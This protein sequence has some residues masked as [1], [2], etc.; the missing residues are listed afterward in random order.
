MSEVELKEYLIRGFQYVL[1]FKFSTSVLK[2][3]ASF[4]YTGTFSKSTNSGVQIRG[5]S[6]CNAKHELTQSSPA[7]YL[8]HFSRAVCRGIRPSLKMPCIN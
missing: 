8:P 5:S 7:N 2:G 6:L 4:H 3:V 1:P